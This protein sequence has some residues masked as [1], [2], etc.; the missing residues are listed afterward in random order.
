MKCFEKL[1]SFS[2]NCNLISKLFPFM[3]SCLQL[4]WNSF[5]VD[6]AKPVGVLKFTSGLLW[7][8]CVMLGRT[9]VCRSV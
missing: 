8:V 1:S 6:R 7:I 2:R 9:M 4:G 3:A 5:R